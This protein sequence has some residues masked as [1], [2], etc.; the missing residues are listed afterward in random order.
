MEDETTLKI[1]IIS[2]CRFYTN[3]TIAVLT[4]SQ[5]IRFVYFAFW[6]RTIW[7]EKFTALKSLKNGSNKFFHSWTVPHL[8]RTR[9]GSTGQME[10]GAFGWIKF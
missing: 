8:S 6:R 1:A 7:F 4:W 3:D 2:R 5:R 10:I 9:K